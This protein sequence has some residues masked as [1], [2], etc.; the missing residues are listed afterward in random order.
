MSS[1]NQFK[2]KGIIV[3]L[4]KNSQKLNLKKLNYLMK[5]FN[6]YIFYCLS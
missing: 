3:L 6:Y 2:I 1:T 4:N 5:I